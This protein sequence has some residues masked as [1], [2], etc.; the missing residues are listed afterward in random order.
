M[1]LTSNGGWFNDLTSTVNP[2]DDKNGAFQ[3][4]SGGGGLEHVSAGGNLAQMGGR[5]AGQV[6]QGSSSNDPAGG[7]GIGGATETTLTGGGYWGDY[8]NQAAD[9]AKEQGQYY[10][11]QMNT[12]GDASQMAGAGANAALTQTGQN[13]ANIGTSAQATMGALGNNYSALLG[14]A[15]S[16]YAGQIGQT[17]QAA[18]GYG[19]GTAGA[20]D[21][22]GHNLSNA[23]G[24]LM[25]QARDAQGR[26]ITGAQQSGLMGIEQQE[27]PSA[28]QGQL[29]L[30]T[31]QN[32]ANALAMARS[33]RGWGGGA[34]A[35][36]QAAAQRVGAQQQSANQSAVLTAQ[37]DAARRQRMAQN[38]GAAG[39][40]ATQQAGTNDA[41][42]NSLNQQ[43]LSAM[44]AGGQLQLGAGGL[45]MSGYGQNLAA[46]QAAA[47]TDI[48]ALGQAGNMAIGANQAGYGMALQGSGQQ[49]QAQ[50]A[51]GGLNLQGYGQAGNLYGNAATYGQN[52]LT[53]QGN[54]EQQGLGWE[55]Q[56]VQNE[57]QAAGINNG[58]AIQQQNQ[59]NQMMGAYTSAAGSVLP[60]L[61]MLSDRNAKEGIEPAN[62]T[63]DPSQG[64]SASA[65]RDR[66]IS[67]EGEEYGQIMSNLRDQAGGAPT[68]SSVV[69]PV[70]GSEQVYDPYSQGVGISGPNQA[71][72]AASSGAA[73]AAEGAEI[74]KNGSPNPGAID[75]DKIGGVG[76]GGNL[77]QTFGGAMQ[78]GAKNAM[79]D[80]SLNPVTGQP[81]MN[82]SSGPMQTYQAPTMGTMGSMQPITSDKREKEAMRTFDETPGYSYDYKDPESMGA[83]D[84]RQYGLMAQDLEKTPAG[85]SV[86]KEVG[87]KKMVDTSRL[88]LV[89]GAAMHGML[90][91]IA[92]LEA[93]LGGGKGKAA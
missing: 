44:Q 70:P 62:V 52:N 30:A 51:G 28:A 46:Q 54:I 92:E 39:Q 40:L 71:Q 77:W 58:L 63:I 22:T 1:G 89:E 11:N 37:E 78:A 86:V 21:I 43:G 69:T 59:G 36:Q 19:L 57:L 35:M 88:T 45:G 42:Q 67:M 14:N 6:V 76:K 79:G 2:F 83:T 31:G 61:A 29:A 64:V 24:S 41:L 26:D 53:L 50:Q 10:Q 17:G 55:Q 32:Q 85:R 9:T 13:A 75:K 4:S 8:G 87:G 3:G 48:G 33:G 15:G 18:Q 90:K 91:R 5:D 81:W 82:T 12:M 60:M 16:Q 65:H 38:Y 93:K 84:G 23:G 72:G 25:S 7:F 49:A 20:V 47:Q 74:G 68:E 56:H 80:T 34:G 27:G 66:G 73:R